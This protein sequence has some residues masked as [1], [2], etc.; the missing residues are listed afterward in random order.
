[1]AT[2][3]EDQ[4]GDGYLHA[5]RFRTLTRLYD[6]VVR[7]TTR[8]ARFKQLLIEQA[9]VSGAQRVL[10]LGCGTGTL[11]LQLKQREPDTKVVGLDADPEMLDQAREKAISA[12]VELEL[13]EGFSTEL[14]YEDSSFDRVLSTLFFHHLDPEPK[15]QTASEIAR[16]LRPRGE[17]HVADWGPPSD[18][19]MRLAFQGIRLL[20]GFSNTA[21]N[22]RGELPAIFEE[23]GLTAAEQTNRLRTPLGSLVLYRA[24]R[25]S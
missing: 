15:R 5:L 20:D 21:A 23:A 17:L 2:P 9:S 11:A 8:E 14:P 19:A 7:L 10:D 24:R 3:T 12:G 16:V 18:P 25:P 22:Y 13:T 6:P 1:M 4:R